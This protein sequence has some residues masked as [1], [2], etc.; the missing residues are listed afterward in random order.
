MPNKGITPKDIMMDNM[1][2]EMLEHLK[3]YKEFLNSLDQ[4][5]EEKESTKNLVSTKSAKNNS[6]LSKNNYKSIRKN[7]NRILKNNNLRR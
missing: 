3:M 7:T 4:F 6:S 5:Q 1:T 2:D